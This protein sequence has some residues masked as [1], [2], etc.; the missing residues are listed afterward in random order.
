MINFTPFPNIKTKNLIIRRMN[1][2]DIHDLFQMRKD[3]R[4]C[5]HIDSKLEETTDE[6]RAYIDKMNK[7][8]DDNKWIIWAIEHK[9]SKKVI[10]TISIWN[11]NEEHESGEL[12]YG[13]IPDYQGEG[14]MKESLL[15]VAQYGFDMM[16]LKALEAYTEENNVKSIR[17]LESCNFIKINR[18]DD[19]GYFNKRVY[20]MIVYRLENRK[21]R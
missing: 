8:V 16:E 20:H 18:V 12:G 15:S 1:Y 13:I 10:G 14:L 17:L 3:P 11:I 7:G 2:N 9:Q 19:V 6:T 21:I 4:M 5:E